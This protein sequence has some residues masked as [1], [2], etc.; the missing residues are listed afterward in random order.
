MLLFTQGA[1]ENQSIK[2][3]YLDG[4]PIG[5]AG[6][7]AMMRVAATVSGRVTITAEA[8][9]LFIRDV[10]AWFSYDKATGLFMCLCVCVCFAQ[11]LL[12]C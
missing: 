12:N 3:I 9:N 11:L 1:T 2:R 8:S 7:K 4:N 6:A 10:K 5:E